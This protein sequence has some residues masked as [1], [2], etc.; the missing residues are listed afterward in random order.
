VG[1]ATFKSLAYQDYILHISNK[2]C[3]IE[4]ELKFY[5]VLFMSIRSAIH[6]VNYNNVTRLC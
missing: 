6:A 5:F 1:L 4:D 2:F 3:R